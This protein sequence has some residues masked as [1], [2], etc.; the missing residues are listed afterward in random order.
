MKQPPRMINEDSRIGI[1]T[2]NACR[3][4]KHHNGIRCHIHDTMIMDSVLVSDGMIYC[5]LF[6]HK[7]K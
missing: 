1:F 3:D 6:V 2:W 4:C 7:E 5:G